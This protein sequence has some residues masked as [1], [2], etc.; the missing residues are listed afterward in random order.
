MAFLNKSRVK[1]FLTNSGRNISKFAKTVDSYGG[2]VNRRTGAMAA[3][4][5]GA[6]TGYRPRPSAY[7]V[8]LR[9]R[10]KAVFRGRRFL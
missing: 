5:Q 4:I 7:Y 8:D 9:P 10:R 3:G 6:F 1:R 2:Q